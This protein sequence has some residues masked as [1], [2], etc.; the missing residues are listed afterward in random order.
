[1]ASKLMKFLTA[2]KGTIPLEDGFEPAL[3]SVA[4]VVSKTSKSHGNTSPCLM[5]ASDWRMIIAQ[6]FLGHWRVWLLWS[7][8]TTFLRPHLWPVMLTASN[9]MEKGLLRWQNA[10]WV[11]HLDWEGYSRWSYRSHVTIAEAD[12]TEANRKFLFESTTSQGTTYPG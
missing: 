5:L 11:R 9:E 1:M 2:D 10:V 12:L 7:R 4:R 3:L 6:I 8:D